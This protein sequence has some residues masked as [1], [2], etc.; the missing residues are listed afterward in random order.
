MFHHSP[1]KTINLKRQLTRGEFA[2]IF[3]VSRST[4]QRREKEGLL[5]PEKVN[6]RVIYYSL[7]DVRAMAQVYAL[8]QKKAITYGVRPE[9]VINQPDN[10]SDKATSEENPQQARNPDTDRG[11]QNPTAPNPNNMAGSDVFLEQL[12]CAL[13]NP[14]VRDCITDILKSQSGKSQV[15]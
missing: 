10:Q 8:D 12:L 14:L 9:D 2:N 11:N 1:S 13:R 4:V 5:K 3:K 15:P 6:A 7:S